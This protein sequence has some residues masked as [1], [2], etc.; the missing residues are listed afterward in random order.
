MAR[1]RKN[2][3]PGP[4]RPKGSPNKVS[5]I[6]KE[7]FE[8]VFERLGGV[9]NMATWAQENQTEF[10]RH[11]AKLI[12]LTLNGDPDSPITYADVS[13]KDRVLKLLPIEQLDAI[14]VTATSGHNDS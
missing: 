3:P 14:L 7:N 1:G 8:T 5:R 4:G 12:P 13:V 11:Y 10:Y 2:M 6:A 9:D